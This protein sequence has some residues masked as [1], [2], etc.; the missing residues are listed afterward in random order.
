MRLFYTLGTL[1]LIL[2]LS[3]NGCNRATGPSGS[4]P[5][6]G[7]RFEKME[8]Q[9]F[10]EINRYRVEQGLAALA[11]SDAASEQARTH[12]RNMAEGKI[13]LGHEGMSQRFDALVKQL[14]IT[15]FAENVALNK[16]Y[17]DPAHDA[18]K[19]WI[20]SPE[21]HDNIVGNYTLTGVGAGISAD[22]TYYFTQIFLR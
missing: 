4:P 14:R 9:V 12:T 20:D 13:P 6:S 8:R 19:G 7:D 1:A 3:L 15:A 18:A 22:G 17:R 5:R 2:L 11:W 16:G 21:H 10:D